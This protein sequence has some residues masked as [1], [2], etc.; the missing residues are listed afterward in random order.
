M[1]LIVCVCVYNMCVY[2]YMYIC[3]Y[4]CIYR[5]ILMYISVYI[6]HWDV[7]KYSSIHLY[8]YIFKD[9]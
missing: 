2:I 3:V 7:I 1:N 6:L 8:V 5:Y 4:I 9:K